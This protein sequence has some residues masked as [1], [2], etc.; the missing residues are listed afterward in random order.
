MSFPP[1]N[2][3]MDLIRRDALEVLSEAELARKIERS[4]TSG[5]PLR[6]KQGFDPTRPDLHIGHAVS[7]EKLRQFQDLG[8]EVIFVVGDYTAR[9]G[10]P[11]GRSELRPQLSPGEIERNAR[12]YREQAALVLDPKRTRLEPNSRWLATLDLADLLRLTS[13]YTVARMLERDDF[14]KRFGEKRAI[15]LVEFMY[16]LLQAYDS[17]VLEADVEL[18]GGDQKFNLLVARTIQ[19]RY[20]QEAQV[21]LLMP[22]LRGTDG[23]R[24]MSKSLDN[25]VA[26]ADPPEEQ[27]G[28]T[29]SAPDALLPEWYRLA[30]GLRGEALD[31][32]L[33]EATADP[34]AAKR[35]LAR[36]IVARFHAPEAADQAEARFDRVH[37]ARGVPD[38]VPLHRLSATDE[39]L[40]VEN[41]E[42]WLPRLLARVGLAPSN[43]QAARLIDEGAVSVDGEKAKDRQIRLPARGVY[44]LQRGK[45]HFARVEFAG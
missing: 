4:I 6:I 41:G 18:G 30:S 13:Q 39:A 24:K 43:S 36:H 5:A 32:A 44:L 34:Y 27:F 2:E 16:P 37:R 35:A 45:R 1:L 40:A 14:S 26:L 22:L 7:L 21:C 33:D 31:E 42:V 10:D 11:S 23:A 20:G 17:V 38:D 15:S 29:M 12:T 8:H 9:I 19:E 28:R 3:Q 25:Y